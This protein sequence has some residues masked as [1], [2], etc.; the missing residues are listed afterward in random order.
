MAGLGEI[1]AGVDL[2]GMPAGEPP[3]GIEP[4]F[5]DPYT[6]GPAYIAVAVVCMALAFSFVATRLYTR[7]FV[8]KNPWWD[9]C[10]C[11]A[12]PGSITQSV[13]NQIISGGS[14]CTCEHRHGFQRCC[15]MKTNKQISYVKQPTA[16]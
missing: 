2:T 3:A 14:N 8:L 7:F 6:R 9:D 16:V 13:A 4:N 5:I 15:R 1:P 10:E 11:S 12:V